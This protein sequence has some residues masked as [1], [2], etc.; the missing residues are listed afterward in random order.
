MTINLYDVATDRLL[1]SIAETDLQMLI[2]ALEEVSTRDQDYYVDTE[3]IDLL[4]E[5]GASAHLL[6]VL[7]H[8]LGQQGNV[9]IRWTRS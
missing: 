7:R 3:T 8:A 5:R 4:A 6:E 1:G 2:E 9:D